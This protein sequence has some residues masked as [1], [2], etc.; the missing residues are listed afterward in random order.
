MHTGLSGKGPLGI[1]PGQILYDGTTRQDSIIAAAGFESM[2]SS[3]IYAF[4]VNSVVLLPRFQPVQ[5]Q[6]TRLQR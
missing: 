4:S 3:R 1:R 6:E 5:S 2:A